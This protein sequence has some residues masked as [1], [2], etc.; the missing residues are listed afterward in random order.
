MQA[1]G[2][3]LL[4]VLKGIL[5][6]LATEKFLTWLFVWIAE[7]IAESTKTKKDDEFVAKAKEIIQE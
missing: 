3:V 7:T 2:M 6:K 1:I 4:N 5:I